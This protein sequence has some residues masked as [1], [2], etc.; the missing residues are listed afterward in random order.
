MF[1]RDVIGWMDILGKDMK[2]VKPGYRGVR[3]LA[4]DMV[5]CLYDKSKKQ[6]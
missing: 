5:Y 2:S 4:G 1:A 6:G 3:F